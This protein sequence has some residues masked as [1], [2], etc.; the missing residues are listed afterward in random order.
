MVNIWCIPRQRI[1][2][3]L[4]QPDLIL[5][6]IMMPGI[7]TKDILKEVGSIKVIFVSAVSFSNEEKKEMFSSKQV[8]DFINK[9]F[10][11][12]N[13]LQRVKRALK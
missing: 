9:P 2:S 5:L 7:P 10:E 3:L 13:L 6:D 4:F 1:N 11:I 12:A 8:V